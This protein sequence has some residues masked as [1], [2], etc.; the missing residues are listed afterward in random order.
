MLTLVILSAVALSAASVY[1]AVK[2]WNALFSADLLGWLCW[3]QIAKGVGEIASS[4]VA[5]ITDN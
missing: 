5:S 3:T 4:L 2:A 1:C